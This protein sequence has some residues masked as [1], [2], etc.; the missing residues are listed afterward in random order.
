L[1]ELASGGVNAVMRPA[2]I[3]LAALP[4]VRAAGHLVAFDPVGFYP[5]GAVPAAA[6]SAILGGAHALLVM[7]SGDAAGLRLAADAGLKAVCAGRPAVREGFVSISGPR[8]WRGMAN[9]PV[10]ALAG[11]QHQLP[12]LGERVERGLAIWL[13]LTERR[14]LAAAAAQA[15]IAPLDR[16]AALIAG[17][18]LAD[19][20]YRL[21]QH[22][23]SGWRDPDPLLALERFAD[24]SARVDVSPGEVAVTLPLGA[25]FAD[26][27]AAG[28][29]DV[30]PRLP[31]L[32]GRVLRVGGG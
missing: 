16:C 21:S 17:F 6:L 5:A 22:D 1:L 30:T 2:L 23:P 14:P 15:Q 26:L 19:I 28:L 31:W 32:R 4:A 12:A 25:R 10:Q 7:P 29:L 9:V 24:L 8:G 13:A 27:F 3:E 20:A 11:H 18:G